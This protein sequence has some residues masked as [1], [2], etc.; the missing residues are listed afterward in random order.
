M[1]LISGSSVSST[2]CRSSSTSRMKSMRR[3]MLSPSSMLGCRAQSQHRRTGNVAPA[4]AA[5]RG[6]QSTSWMNFARQAH[7]D[8]SNMLQHHCVSNIVSQ[9]IRSTQSSVGSANTFM[10][11]TVC[12]HTVSPFHTGPLNTAAAPG[13]EEVDRVHLTCEDPR[14]RNGSFSG[15]N[16][17]L[18]IWRHSLSHSSCEDPSVEESSLN[19]SIEFRR[20]SAGVALRASISACRRGELERREGGI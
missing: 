10:F 14:K 9:G 3:S 8:F 2:S 20:R 4:T 13:T 17:S 19:W 7:A 11:Y 12:A 5:I 16:D 1:S 15:T 6:T 18:I